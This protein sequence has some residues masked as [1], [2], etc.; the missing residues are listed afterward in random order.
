MTEKIIEKELSCLVNRCTF[1]VHNEVGP[2]FREECYQK[3]MEHRRLQAD[4]PLIPKPQTRTEL[5]HRGVVVNV[6][7]PNLLI[8]DRMIVELK[9]QSEGFVSDH[10]ILAMRIVLVKPS[11]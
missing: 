3:A 4:I 7:E 10:V 11:S 6:F 2:V 8:P 1:D 5:E 9:H